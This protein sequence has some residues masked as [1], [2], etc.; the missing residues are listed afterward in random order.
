MISHISCSQTET[1]KE[2]RAVT[3]SWWSVGRNIVHLHVC[4]GSL[5]QK[6]QSFCKCRKMKEA[7]PPCHLFKSALHVDALV[8]RGSRVGETVAGVPPSGNV[9]LLP[10]QVPEGLGH[11]HHPVVCQR[12]SVLGDERRWSETQTSRT[13][14]QAQ[15]GCVQVSLAEKTTQPHTKTLQ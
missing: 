5:E 2:L 10:A 12:W 9:H 8:P 7:S 14:M 11:H 13:F 15:L 1:K 6:N 4:F 3:I